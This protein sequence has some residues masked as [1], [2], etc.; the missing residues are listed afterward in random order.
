[1]QHGI[2]NLKVTCHKNYASM[3]MHQFIPVLERLMVTKIGTPNNDIIRGTA[4][5]DIIGGRAGNDKIYGLGGADK[6]YGDTNNDILYGGDGNDQIYGGPGN[7][8]I[9]GENGDDTLD[10]QSGL[11]VI[12]GGAGNDKIYS[13]CEV[14]AGEIGY[15]DLIYAGPG[16]DSIVASY[17]KIFGG[18]GDD[19]FILCGSIAFGEKGND[20]FFFDID[21][22]VGFDGFGETDATVYGGPGSDLLDFTT[23][24]AIKSTCGHIRVTFNNWEPGVDR[25]TG[26][27][28]THR[29]DGPSNVCDDGEPMSL[30]G[31]VDYIRRNFDVNRDGHVGKADGPQFYENGSKLSFP[32]NPLTGKQSMLL[33]LAGNELYL[34]DVTTLF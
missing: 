9:Y 25:L 30:G 18:D 23:P 16:N 17:D 10:G 3:D 34:P 26:T 24:G 12:Y 19:T 4:N 13:S 14:C 8:T 28:W 5:A 11:D 33:E 2:S 32:I 7:D 1:M 21:C 6:L 31:A 29:F 20:K 15:V 22:D 27:L